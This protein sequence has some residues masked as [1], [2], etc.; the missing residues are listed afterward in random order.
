MGYP[1][2]NGLNSNRDRP[3]ISYNSTSSMDI[4]FNIKAQPEAKLERFSEFGENFVEVLILE[5]TVSE[6][7][8]GLKKCYVKNGKKCY[9]G[10]H[11]SEKHVRTRKQKGSVALALRP[12]KS[13]L[14]MPC[15]ITL[16]RYAPI[17]LDKYDNL[18][19]SLKYILDAV[20]EVI[21]DD[22][23]PGRADAHEGIQDVQ[24]RQIKCKEYGV[25][26]RIDY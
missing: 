14:R 16:T 20:C 15:I 1:F 18:P 8:G 17:M 2:E 21:T 11:W 19:V 5:T 26:I 13:H 10:E 25:K 24:Y 23:R 7:N 4:A 6:A 3:T 22:Y 9:K 12:L